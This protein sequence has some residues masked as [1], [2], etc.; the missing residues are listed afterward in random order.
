MRGFTSRLNALSI[1]VGAPQWPVVIAD[2]PGNKIVKD[3]ETVLVLGA[4][5]DPQAGFA[6]VDAL[7][8]IAGFADGL[9]RDQSGHAPMV[10]RSR[11]RVG[12]S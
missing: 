6:A 7:A 10:K 8:Q 5:F 9:E 4:A 1:V 3:V 2:I 11:A 12:D